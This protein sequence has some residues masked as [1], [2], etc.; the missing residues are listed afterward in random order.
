MKNKTIVF[1]GGYRIEYLEAIKYTFKDCEISTIPESI[2]PPEIEK[3]AKKINDNYSQVIFFDYIYQF[4]SLVPII[5][6][7]VKKKWIIRTSIPSLCDVDIYNNFFQIIEYMDRNLLD[8][9]GV[10]DYDLYLTFNKKYKDR[11]KYLKLDLSLK[12]NNSKEEALGIIG[13]DYI[14][15]DNFFNQLSAATLLDYKKVIVQNTM[16]VT[17]NFAKEF[18]LNIEKEG[19]IFSL[20]NRSQ[21][22]IYVGFYDIAV[23]NFLYSMDNDTL[24]LLGNTHLLDDNEFLKNLLVVNSDDDIDEIASKVKSVIENKDKIFEE[25][26]QFRKK[27]SDESKKLVKEFLSI[28]EHKDNNQSKNKGKNKK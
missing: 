11:C 10:I 16:T 25:Y 22:I 21:L 7:K 18:N 5:S 23:T 2:T 17:K 4:Y 19:N 27:Y 9:I 6:K 13:C 8:E 24:C 26:K 1:I 14:N 28:V 3:L 12:N 20:I 15:G